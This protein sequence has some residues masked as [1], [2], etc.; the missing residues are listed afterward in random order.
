M[1]IKA[2]RF[3]LHEHP[4]SATSWQM[5]EVVEMQVREGIF[6]NVCDM[7]AYGMVGV[8][9]LG[10]A[11]AKKRTRPMSNAYE[12]IKR[13]GRKCENLLK[14]SGKRFLAPTDEAARPKFPGVVP[15]CQCKAGASHRHADL[16]GQRAKQ[17]QVYPK[18]FCV[19]VCEGVAAQKRLMK[20]GLK[21]EPILSLSEMVD[22]V[23][24]GIR[25]G[26]RG[27]DLH[28]YEDE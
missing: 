24:E 12:V 23:P 17:C 21:S 22:A 16:T 28:E 4:D 26:D 11:P 14:E 2:H 7:C 10:E 19:A 9:E 27:R 15:A 25:T 6:A 1:Q 5:P 20:M 3:F 8:D 18:A 13:L